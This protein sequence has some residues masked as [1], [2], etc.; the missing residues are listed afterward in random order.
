MVKRMGKLKYVLK[1]IKNM[2]FGNFFKTVDDVHK[3]CGKP[4]VVVFFDAI[5]CGFKYQAGYVDYQLFEMYKMN[6]EERKTI[7]TRGINNDIIKKYNKSEYFKYFNDKYE[8]NKKFDKY[9]MRD[10]LYLDGN[11]LEDFK[12]FLKGKK[13]IIVKP[14]V[15]SCGKGVDKIKVS[16]YKP[17]ELYQ[18]LVSENRKLVE[19]V[20]IQCKEISKL[21]PTSINTVRVVTLNG[22]VVVAFLRMGN[23][24]YV[25]DNFNHEGL[26]APIDVETGTIKYIAIDKQHNEYEIHPYTNEK[27]VGLKIPMWK[28][29]VKLCEDASKVIPEIGYVGWDVCVGEKTPFLIEGNEFPGHD[30]YQ[31]PPHRDGNIGLMPVFNKAM[32][33]GKKE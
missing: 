25:V 26:V 31:L 33:E 10:W 9:L 11:N 2:N 4:R 24:G 32:E 23:K 14:T 29:I 5:A 21:H 30:L 8:F 19:E 22:T 20:A 27:I 13:E 6:K 7:I 16:D 17:E 18:K 12:K 3:K 1:R 15:G 28:E